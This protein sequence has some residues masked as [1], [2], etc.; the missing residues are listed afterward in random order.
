[1]KILSTIVSLCAL[2]FTMLLSLLL[3]LLNPEAVSLDFLGLFV[4]HQS[5]GLLLLIAFVSGI[6]LCLLGSFIPAWI[7][8]YKNQRLRKRL[9]K[10]P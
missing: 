9:E 1:M 6:L 7:L 3:V 4:V 5:L 10:S 2:L 8:N